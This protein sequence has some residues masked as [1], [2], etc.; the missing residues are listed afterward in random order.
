MR[1]ITAVGRCM[2][3]GFSSANA[4]Q[5]ALPSVAC[6]P[7]PQLNVWHHTQSENGQAMLA[8][9]YRADH[10]FEFNYVPAQGRGAYLTNSFDPHRIYTEERSQHNYGTWDNRC[11]EFC[12]IQAIGAR[13]GERICKHN[14]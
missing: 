1:L 8:V 12:W 2:C 9:M 3:V 5:G 13:A 10:T 6:I 14:G 4:Q 7:D 11:T